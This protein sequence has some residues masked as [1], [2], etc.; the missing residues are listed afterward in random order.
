MRADFADGRTSSRQTLLVIGRRLA[1]EWRPSCR[2]ERVSIGPRSVA[3]ALAAGVAAGYAQGCAPSWPSRSRS[4]RATDRAGE[5]EGPCGTARPGSEAVFAG[6]GIGDRD[7]RVDGKSWRSI[8]VMCRDAR[9]HPRGSWS[10][11]RVRVS[12]DARTTGAVARVDR[13]LVKG[14]RITSGCEKAV[15]APRRR[16][17]LDRLAVAMIRDQDGTPLYVV[18]MGADATQRHLLLEQ[19]RMRPPTIR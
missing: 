6:A 3:G 7:R 2:Y 18:V 10:R 5:A 19:L 1:A 15:R 16:P 13:R 17:D 12:L 9:P 8:A 4:R 14:E 11:G